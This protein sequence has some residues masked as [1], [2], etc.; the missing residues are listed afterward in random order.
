MK[1]ATFDYILPQNVEEVIEL[2]EQHEDDA[3]ILAGGQSL[4]PLMNFRLARPKILID[5]NKIPSLSEIKEEGDQLLI[6]AL[7]RENE[8]MNSAL[9][10]E[11]CPV[12]SKAI[13]KIG[14]STIRNRGTVGGSVVHCDP[15][16]ELPVV[17]R[18]LNA[19]MRVIGTEGERI[20]EAEDFFVTY[21]TSALEPSEILLEVRL[22]KLEKGCGW[23]FVEISRRAGDFAIVAVAVVLMT[24]K[25]GV[26]TEVRIALGGVDDRP[27]RAEE[28]ENYL[29][30]KVA[31]ETVFESA[32]KLATEDLDP[33]SDYHA[34]GEYRQHMAEVLVVKG[35][36][37]ALVRTKGDL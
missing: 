15:S 8:A 28:A 34:S 23:S 6:G 17:S 30:G 7:T 10:M 22:P 3:K 18:V 27:I 31:D 29:V 36:K 11:H 20:I 37:E 25:K 5:I 14:H 9:V 21:L 4:I 32:A 16:A 33:E 19:Q 13:S 26:C 2:L 35:L 1:P 24:D 12:F